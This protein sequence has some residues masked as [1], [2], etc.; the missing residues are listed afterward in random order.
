LL[1]SCIQFL[2]LGLM[3]TLNINDM[4]EVEKTQYVFKVIMGLGFGL[5]LTSLLTLIPLVVKKSDIPVVIG[6]SYAGEESTGSLFFTPHSHLCSLLSAP[7]TL[8][9]S[10]TAQVTPFALSTLLIA[11]LMSSRC[12]RSE[13]WVG[14]LDWRSVRRC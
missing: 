9:L 6:G 12:S 3:L 5:V 4:N 11:K 13:F 2:G 7:S 1:D 10:P 14:R 8:E